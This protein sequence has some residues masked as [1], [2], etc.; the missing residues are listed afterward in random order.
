MQTRSGAT[1]PILNTDLLRDFF[2]SPDGLQ[3]LQTTRN[4]NINEQP[5][6]P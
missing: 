4:V 2:N 1:S 6:I 3:I 5:Y